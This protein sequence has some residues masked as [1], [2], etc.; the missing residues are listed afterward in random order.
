[1]YFSSI[2]YYFVLLFC[3]AGTLSSGGSVGMS[4]W[5]ILGWH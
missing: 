2:R 1:M 4:C 5:A 3:V